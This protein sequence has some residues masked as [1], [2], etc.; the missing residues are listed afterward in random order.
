L[1]SKQDG[2]DL[3][4]IVGKDWMGWQEDTLAKAD[5]VVNLV[6]GYTG[7]RVMATERIVRESLS[8][9]PQALQ[10]TVSPN[11]EELNII[12]P[13]AFEIKNERIKL[14]EEIVSSNCANSV[15]IRLEANR[16]EESCEKLKQ[17]IEDLGETS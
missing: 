16:L 6:G 14:C 1:F 13:G 10:V 12:S 2:G 5:V 4:D 8:F 7:Q 15:C 17:I 3:T 11:E 9:N